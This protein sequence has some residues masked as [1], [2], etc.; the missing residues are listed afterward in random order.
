MHGTTPIDWKNLRAGAGHHQNS[1]Y[2]PAGAAL[3]TG[4][5]TD[6][7]LSCNALRETVFSDDPFHLLADVGKTSAPVWILGGARTPIGSLL[8]DNPFKNG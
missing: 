1:G 7:P 3:L 8:A 2:C 4:R 5:A 6:L